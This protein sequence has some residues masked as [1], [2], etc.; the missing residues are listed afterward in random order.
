MELFHILKEEVKQPVRLLLFFVFISGFINTV[1]IAIIN[2]AA[3]QVANEDIN[4]KLFLLFAIA[5]TIYV[6]SKKYVLDKSTIMI[7]DVLYRIRQRLAYKVS[8]AELSTLESIG[9]APIYARLSQDTSMVSNTSTILLNAIQ[10]SIMVIFIILYIGT[11]SAGS[12]IIVLSIMT[13]CIAIYFQSSQG[14]REDWLEVA[15]KETY[16]FASLQHILNGFKEI[17]INRNKNKS[18]LTNY[19]KVAK[20]IK[21]QRIKTNL[22]YNVLMVFSQIFFYI[23]LGAVVFVLPHLHAEHAEDIIKVTAALLFMIGPFES[24]M[25]SIQ[26]FITANGAARNI[27]DLETMLEKELK[28]NELSITIHNDP[29]SFQTLSYEHNIQLQNLVYA[30]PPTKEQDYIFQVGPINLTLNKGELIFITGGNGSGKSTFLKLLTGLYLPQSGKIYIDT[31]EKN[32]AKHIVTPTNYQRYRNL[33]T[34]IFTD[35]HL[36]DKLYGVE[37]PDPAIVNECL[38]NMELPPEKTMYRN[39]GFTNIKLSSGQKKRLALTSSILENKDIYIFDEVAAD[40]D[41]DFRD[42]YYYEIIQELTHR[43]KT[44]IVVSHD[45]H[46]WTVPDRLLEMVNGQIR[47]LTKEEIASLVKL[48]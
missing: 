1:L 39:G 34:T 14:F 27:L 17:K 25:S 12:F 43:G 18:V 37:N 47:E 41:P 24:V 16:F 33:F 21:K 8:L 36:F 40:L 46:Y 23:L 11:I 7:E 44:V 29:S 4:N 15:K 22:G 19:N 26:I 3:E 13:I 20:D 35:F 42:K 45:R 5:V 32:Y 10:S 6:I 48:N 38:V 2:N 9:T 31:D 30:Y 28:Q